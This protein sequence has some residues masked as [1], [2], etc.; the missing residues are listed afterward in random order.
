ME[1]IRG[2]FLLYI[3]TLSDKAF[4]ITKSLADSSSTPYTFLLFSYY[5]GKYDIFFLH[6]IRYG[7]VAKIMF[8]LKLFKICKKIKLIFL[9]YYGDGGEKGGG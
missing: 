2:Y 6:Y 3:Y 4:S 1:T 9:N 8:H 7:D 5:V